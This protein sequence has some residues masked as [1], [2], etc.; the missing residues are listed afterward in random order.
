MHKKI[1]NYFLLTFGYLLS[2]LSWWNDLFIN[3]PIAY[4]FSIPFDFI[5][6]HL[7]IVIFIINYWLTNVI[8]FVLMHRGIS[9]AI[10]SKQKKLDIIKNIL[11]TVVYTVVVIILILANIIK[12]PLELNW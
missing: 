2:P 8:G 7:F 1:K 11:I 4:I 12:S 3:I 9:N 10:N 5:N 6:H